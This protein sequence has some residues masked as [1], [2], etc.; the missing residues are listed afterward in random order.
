MLSRKRISIGRS[1]T[2][3]LGLR[4]A[5]WLSRIMAET[6]PPPRRS[7][8]SLRALEIPAEKRLSIVATECLQRKEADLKSRGRCSVCWH[9]RPSCICQLV[10]PLHLRLDVRFVL[11][12]HYLEYTNAGDDGKLLRLLAPDRTD[13]CVF[14]RPGDDERLKAALEGRHALLLFPSETAHTVDDLSSLG[15]SFAR[16]ED[17][18]V[19]SAKE[20]GAGPGPCVSIIVLDGTWK[21][22]RAMRRHFFRTEGLRNVPEIKLDPDS[23]AY[24]AERGSSSVYARTQSQA[25]RVCTLEAIALLL[26]EAGEDEAN[27]DAIIDSVVINN[28][29]VHGRVE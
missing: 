5:D 22:V 10:A 13:L 6:Q 14:G 3:V 18:V 7:A 12:M 16:R 4:H 27:C 23:L 20:A 9:A 17:A 2:E 8:Q 28:N 25:D 15:I 21:Q 29:S 1:H 26:R 19:T 11:Y 24:W